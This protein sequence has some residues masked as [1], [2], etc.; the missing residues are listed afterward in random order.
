MEVQ[1]QT[2]VLHSLRAVINILAS[3]KAPSILSAFLAGGNLTALNKSKSDGPFDIRPITVGE[4]LRHLT[5]K[6]LCTTVKVKATDFFHPFQFGVACPF[7]AEIIHGLRACIEEHWGEDGF[8]VLKI[9][10][11][12]AF[13]VVSR[14]SLLSEG[15]KH[16]PELLPWASWC[17]GQRPFCGI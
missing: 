2:P 17:Y 16:F 12:N 7:G 9:D 3:G 4:A 13:N 6:C 14:Q 15:A 10:M 11:R 8:A 5:G 1:L